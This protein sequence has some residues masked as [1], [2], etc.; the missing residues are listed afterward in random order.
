M[1]KNLTKFRNLH[2]DYAECLEHLATYG[3]ASLND[4][5]RVYARKL[6]ALAE[7]YIEIINEEIDAEDLDEEEEL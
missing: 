7:E 3:L 1:A 5:E 4:S 2:E 6:A